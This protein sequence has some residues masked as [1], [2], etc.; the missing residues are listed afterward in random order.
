[1]S[2]GPVMTPL[3]QS[4]YNTEE[5]LA[6][7]AKSVPMNRVSQPEEIAK[8]VIYLASDDSSYVTGHSLVIDGGSLIST[9]YLFGLLS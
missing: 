8:T 1:V 2:P 6:R 9:F 5:L 4:I 7:R 3:F